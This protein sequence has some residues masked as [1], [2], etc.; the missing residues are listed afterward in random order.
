MKK[1]Q[2]FS[3]V[4]MNQEPLD[5]VNA[6]YEYISKMKIQAQF[7]AADSKTEEDEKAARTFDNLIIFKGSKS[8][9]LTFY[10]E[11]AE[12]PAVASTLRINSGGTKQIVIKKLKL[13]HYWPAS[14]TKFY[15]YSHLD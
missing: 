12:P 6:L 14:P 9:A 13:P 2:A 3:G 8:R 1:I 10:I 4:R 15:C 11:K 5:K 7:I